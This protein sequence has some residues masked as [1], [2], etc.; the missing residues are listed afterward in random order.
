[1]NNKFVFKFF[2]KNNV[3]YITQIYMNLCTYINIQKYAMYII[4]NM[5]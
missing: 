4:Y 1:M 2:I 5:Q 3:I